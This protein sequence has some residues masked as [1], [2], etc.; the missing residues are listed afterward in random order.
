M[1]EHEGAEVES[2]LIDKTKVGQAS[3]QVWS[4][5][6]NLPERAEPSARAAPSRRHS[7]TSVALG[8]TDFNERDTTHFGW[9]RHTAAKSRSSALPLGM[10]FVPIT[11]DLVRAAT[12]HTAG[13]VAHVLYEVTKERGAWRPKFQVVDVAVQGLLQSEDEFRHACKC[14]Q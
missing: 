10:V 14:N 4:G 7:R 13:Q 2:I 5:D 11:H 1:T 9:L 8:P 6:R 12:I 3:R